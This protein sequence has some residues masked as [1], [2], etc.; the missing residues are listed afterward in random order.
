MSDLTIL[1]SFLA[2]YRT[3]SVSRAAQQLQLAQPTVTLHVKSLEAEIGRQLFNRRPRGVE[4]RNAAHELAGAVSSH[5]DALDEVLFGE[6]I[7]RSRRGGVLYIG[8]PSEYVSAVMLPALDE[9]VERGVRIRAMLDVNEPILSALSDGEVDLAIL[10]ESPVDPSIEVSSQRMEEYVLVSSPARAATI[11]HILEGPHGAEQLLDE[12]LVAFA[13]SLPLIRDYWRNVFNTQWVGSPAIVANSLPAL[14]R[15][16]ERGMGISVFP[17][18]MI[19]P[20]LRS[21]ELVALLEPSLPPRNVM[22][23]AWRAG[24]MANPSI[25]TAREL[26]ERSSARAIHAPQA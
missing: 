21:G 20:S 25:R 6:V 18:H 15:L 13:E 9:L 7:G 24:A 4:P 23:L 26:L 11:G 2:V 1:R 10:T 19:A 16:V 12:P 5:L 14:A 22:Y 17:R 3:G 8:G